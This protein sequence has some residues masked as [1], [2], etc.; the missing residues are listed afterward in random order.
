MLNKIKYIYRKKIKRERYLGFGETYKQFQTTK[1]EKI[2][3]NAKNI[4][5][6][7]ENIREKKTRYRALKRY[8]S[9]T[10]I[11]KCYC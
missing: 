10:L 8:S 2:L 7:I 4:Q 11:Y 9:S 5:I 1:K 6:S 3:Q